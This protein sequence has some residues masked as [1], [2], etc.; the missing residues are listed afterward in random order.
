MKET[1]C[2]CLPSSY[3][4]QAASLPRMT[5]SN[6]WSVSSMDEKRYCST[7]STLNS[8][9]QGPPSNSLQLHVSFMNSNFIFTTVIVILIVIICSVH[10]PVSCVHR[11]VL[12]SIFLIVTCT[13][14]PI[15]YVVCAVTVVITC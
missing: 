6:S 15:A 13:Y 12:P 4:V 3:L 5:R 9:E 10:V 7:A 2:L 11:S 1:F 14:I 8:F